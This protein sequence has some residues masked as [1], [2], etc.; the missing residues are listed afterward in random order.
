M[1]V[2]PAQ[3]SAV[4]CERVFSSS[5]E[6]CSQCRNRLSPKLMEALQMLKFSYKQDQLSF[7]DDLL[8]QEKDYTITGP[9]TPCTITELVRAGRL[10]E[11][12]DL[13]ANVEAS[14]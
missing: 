9:V 11:L 12:D 14:T 8:A 13:L 2:L 6:T 10:Q 3:A 7:A 1:D 4:P 5:K